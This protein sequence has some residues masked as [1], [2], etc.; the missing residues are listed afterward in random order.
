ME[1]E[2][3]IY[4]NE[5]GDSLELSVNSIFH[6]NVSKDVTGLSDVRNTIYSWREKYLKQYNSF[7]P[8]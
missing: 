2:R 4:T 1:Y 3:L 8:F 5:R 7:K 6:C